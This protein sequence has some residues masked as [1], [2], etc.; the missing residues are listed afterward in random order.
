MRSGQACGYRRDFKAPGVMS[1]SLLSTVLISST[2]SLQHSATS[3]SCKK[4]SFLPVGPVRHNPKPTCTSTEARCVNLYWSMDSGPEAG[5]W[6]AAA[7]TQRSQRAVCRLCSFS[8]GY[9]VT[10]TRVYFSIS[11]AGFA[12][13]RGANRNCNEMTRRM[14]LRTDRMVVKT[15]IFEVDRAFHRKIA[16]VNVLRRKE[17][18]SEVLSSALFLNPYTFSLD[19]LPP[20]PV[21]GSTR[22]ARRP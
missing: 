10:F 1:S 13:V 11:V 16:R 20:Q 4:D 15:E 14:R 5:P 18:E 6:Q 21:N 12:L 19:A 9:V 22:R 17:K 8:C 2:I 3:S 7:H